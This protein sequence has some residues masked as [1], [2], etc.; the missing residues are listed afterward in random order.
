MF[1]RGFVLGQNPDPVTKDSDV[2]VFMVPG[3]AG[4]YSIFFR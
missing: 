1:E 4:I 3:Q 2:E